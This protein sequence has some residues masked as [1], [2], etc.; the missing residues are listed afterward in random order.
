MLFGIDEIDPL[1]GTVTGLCDGSVN[2]T[3]LGNGPIRVLDNCLLSRCRPYAKPLGRGCNH[4][5]MEYSAS[6]PVWAVAGGFAF[7]F[8]H[9]GARYT[10]TTIVNKETVLY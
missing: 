9:W 2:V 3:P 4:L 8:R 6:V 5:E 1:L 10:T 7:S